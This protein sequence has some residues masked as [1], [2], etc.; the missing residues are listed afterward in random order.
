MKKIALLMMMTSAAWAT[1]PSFTKLLDEAK[2]ETLFEQTTD[3]KRCPKTVYF[4][5]AKPTPRDARRG[6]GNLRL[7]GKEGW[8]TSEINS[9]SYKLDLKEDKKHV[10]DRN[11]SLPLGIAY[12]V[13]SQRDE[14][15]LITFKTI[16]AVF[17]PFMFAR[18]KQKIEYDSKTDSIDLF[19]RGNGIEDVKC[20]FDKVLK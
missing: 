5:D 8:F 3:N 19:F 9:I 17:S 14:D 16:S 4:Y 15:G 20:R 18:L 6:L 12:S 7:F 10:F 1:S 11:F 13:S 2:K